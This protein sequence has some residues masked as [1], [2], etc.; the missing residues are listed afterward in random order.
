MG[1]GS[2][3]AGRVAAGVILVAAGIVAVLGTSGEVCVPPSPWITAGGIGLALACLPAIRARRRWA[4]PVAIVL[5]A[6]VASQIHLRTGFPR[7][8]DARLHLWSLWSVHRCI[9]DGDLY[10]RWNPYLGL[11]YP[12][13][14]FYPPAV[15]L[16]AQPLMA[17]GLTPVQTVAAL[18]LAASALSGW[19]TAWAAGRLGVS[20]PARL[21][22]AAAC[23][24]APYHLHDANYRLALTEL[25]GIALLPLFLVLGRE[26][27]R[28]IGGAGARWRFLAV[29]ALLLVTHLLSALMGGI[30]LGLWVL[31]EGLLLG[32]RRWAGVGLGLLRLGVLCAVAAGLAG[33]FLIPCLGEKG[34][35]SIDM[36]NPNEDRPLSSN[37]IP[38]DD[39]VERRVWVS[40]A[41]S[42]P[43]SPEAGVEPQH[44]LPYYVGLAL[45]GAALA[46]LLLALG[47]RRHDGG[48]SRRATVGLGVTVLACLLFSAGIPA[49]VLDAVT[50]LRALQFPWRF[51]GPA[52]VG[53]ALAAAIALDRAARGR[54]WRVGIAAGALLLLVADAYPYL[55]AADWRDPYEGAVHLLRVGDGPT[56]AARTEPIDAQLPE[57]RFVRIERMRFPPSH[58]RYRVAKAH[59]VHKEYMT[60]I[61]HRHYQRAGGSERDRKVSARYGVERRYE[62]SQRDPLVF[63]ARSLASFRPDDGKRFDDLAGVPRI[64]PERITVELPADQPAGRV[65]VLFQAFPGWLFRVDGGAWETAGE[66]RGLLAARVPAG[67]REVEFRYSLR[68]PARRLGL[69]ATLV[70]GAGVLF[71]LGRRWR[72]AAAPLTD[73]GRER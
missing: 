19:T 30:A 11:G 16:A 31:V 64:E 43:K 68:T 37:G 8:H 71:L 3:I 2:R 5:L 61:I 46:A 57:G 59:Y 23:M 10:P 58:F 20:R 1:A 62:D 35:T 36:V 56:A 17:L 24:L 12:L 72:R 9:L 42:R 38:L 28:G 4:L 25:F 41:G 66:A 65:R 60:P 40:Y 39:L 21:V 53:A 14:Q 55:G 26:V 52:S 47:P 45:L 70:T 15:Y 49:P 6:L 48:L 50:P 29:A 69:A 54:W 44:V 27:V 32:P 7:M 67:A 33:A 22:A 51:L 34:Q 18:V 73:R 13:L 63:S